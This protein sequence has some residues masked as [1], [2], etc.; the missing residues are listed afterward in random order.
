MLKV[1]CP[2]VLIGHWFDLYLMV[3][4]GVMKNE[5]AF[6]FVE[7]GMLCVFTAIFLFVT[8][9]SLAKYPLV[10]KNEPMM[11]EALNHHI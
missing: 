7:I 8:L 5:G 11:G 4:P 1:V 6:G 2:I 9:S 10:A 3:T